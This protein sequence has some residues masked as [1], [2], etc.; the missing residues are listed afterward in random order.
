MACPLYMSHLIVASSRLNLPKLEISWCNKTDVKSEFMR[1]LIHCSHHFM[2][3]SV[4]QILQPL[5]V[6]D[7]PW[8]FDQWYISRARLCSWWIIFK[9]D[10]QASEFRAVYV[11]CT[12][13]AVWCHQFLLLSRWYLWMKETVK[14]LS[15]ALSL[16][17]VWPIQTTSWE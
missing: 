9:Q 14:I 3:N 16:Y 12:F 15:F 8:Q 13:S 7:L 10:C 6:W 4:K 5:K 2:W 1:Q 11:T 17:A